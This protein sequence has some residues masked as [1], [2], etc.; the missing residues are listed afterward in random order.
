[1]GHEAGDKTLQLVAQRLSTILRTQDLV[2]RIGGDEFAIIIN[3]CHARSEITELCARL[4]AAVGEP[5]M[6]GDAQLQ[7]GASIGSA[8]Y[9]TEG[10][11]VD[12]IFKMA[13]IDMYAA[14]QQRRQGEV[15]RRV[16]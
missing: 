4:H 5:F 9:P 15:E 3:P 2:A 13:A 6:I 10:T 7:V 8:I 12:Q 16:N 11:N 1:M 14:K